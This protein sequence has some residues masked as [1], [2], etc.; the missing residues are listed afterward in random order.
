MTILTPCLI[1]VAKRLIDHFL[2]TNFELAQQLKEGVERTK[3]FQEAI[4]KSE[5]DTEYFRHR[6]ET[7]HNEEIELRAKVDMSYAYIKSLEVQHNEAK[8]RIDEAVANLS[9]ADAV[10][11]P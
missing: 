9:D 8:K 7:L 5:E 3:Q 6:L 4:V 2:A 1:W 11:Q 10:R